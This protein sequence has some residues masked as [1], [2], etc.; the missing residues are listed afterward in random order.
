MSIDTY[1]LTSTEEPTDEVLQALMEKV[2]QAARESNA[3]A[4]SEKRR[5]LQIVADEIKE[6][7]RK[8]AV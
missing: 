8:V 6:W 2:A 3:K 1:K 4:E 5:R 7:K